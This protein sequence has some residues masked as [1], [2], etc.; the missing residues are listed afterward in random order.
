MLPFDR[1]LL[2]P[3]EFLV[4]FIHPAMRGSVDGGLPLSEIAATSLALTD[5]L[6]RFWR[7]I[8]P[9]ARMP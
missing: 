7:Q 8:A 4:R 3:R 5:S 2:E 1:S 6:R 9:L